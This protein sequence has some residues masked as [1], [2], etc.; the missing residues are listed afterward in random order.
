MIKLKYKLFPQSFVNK[1]VKTI[2]L[3]ENS[4]IAKSNLKNKF[5]LD[6]LEVKY[7]LGYKLK[8]LIELVNTNNVREFVRRLETIHS[9]DGCI[10]LETITRILKE[11]NISYKEYETTDYEYYNKKG[12]KITSPAC[13]LI[14]I[15]ITNPNHNQHLEIEI[16]KSLDSVVDLWFGSYWFEYYECRSEQEFIDSYINTIKDIMKDKMKVICYHSKTNNRW[17]ASYCYYKDENP[18]ID[19]SED[20][21]K[22]MKLLNDNKIAR[23]ENVFCY[24]WSE[25]KIYNKKPGE[26]K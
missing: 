23:R 15:E 17:H 14:I 3:S 26:L 13:D 6:D 20:L 1:I 18:E 9:L 24:T 11:N 10:G 22:H 25:L 8:Y 2:Q 7:I 21:E 19:D 4:E 12:S 16:D 5:G